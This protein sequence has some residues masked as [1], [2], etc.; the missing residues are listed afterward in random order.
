MEKDTLDLRSL[1]DLLLRRVWIILGSAVLMGAAF[2]AFAKFV[3]PLKY[4]SYTSMYVKNNTNTKEQQT[5]ININDLNASKSLVSTY[6]AV[7]DSDTVMGSVGEALQLKFDKA[8]LE[9]SFTFD[10]NGKINIESVRKCFTMS[11]VDDTEVMNITAIT[12]DPQVSAHMCN[13]IAD[14]APE[15]L[16]RVVGAGSVEVIDEA[17]VNEE[18]VSPNFRSMVI[19]GVLAGLVLSVL[20]VILADMF[21]NTIKESDKLVRRFGKA[22]L[23][24]IME[25]EGVNAGNKKVKKSTDEERLLLTD[26]ERVPFNVAETYKSIRTNLMFS[27]GTTGKNTIAVSSCNPSEGKSTSAAN[28]ALAFAQT[29]CSVLLIDAD[30]RK[31]VQHKI[32]KTSNKVGLSTMI[33]GFSSAEDSIQK[34]IYKNLDLLPAGKMPPNPSEL[35][36]SQQFGDLLN[37]VSRMYDYVIIDTPPVNI[38]SDA[39]VIS[40]LVGG[41]VMVLKYGATTYDDMGEAMKQLNL[42]DV[43]VLGFVLNEVSKHHAGTYYSYKY[44]Y[45]YSDYGYGYG[46]HSDDDDSD[47]DDDN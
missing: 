35:L 4:E 47:N 31:P 6:I 11:S 43:N 27:L 45:K 18:A 5:D 21:D 14:I 23:G 41:A 39:V 13:V 7:L 1:L 26:T 33:V 44:K 9:G 17:K 38:V 42:S 10:D 20:I 30:M 29:G 8:T 37:R 40:G 28:V 34:H 32:F 25:I 46:G 3:M 15:F 19:R 36:S 12:T 24:E 16:V 22:T 2:F